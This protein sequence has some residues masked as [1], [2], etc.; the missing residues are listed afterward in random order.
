M[1]KPE[2]KQ[3]DVACFNVLSRLGV[4]MSDTKRAQIQ[5]LVTVELGGGHD[6]WML[7]CYVL[8]VGPVPGLC[9]RALCDWALR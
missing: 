7:K 4:E 5:C 2:R 9:S 3:A 8:N 6:A 1:V